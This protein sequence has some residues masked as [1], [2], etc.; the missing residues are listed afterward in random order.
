MA[1]SS[2]DVRL[3]R[4]IAKRLREIAATYVTNMSEKVLEV[5]DEFD[6]HADALE[7]RQQSGVDDD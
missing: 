2:N 4:D 5:A 6:Q 3:L 1:S 7:R